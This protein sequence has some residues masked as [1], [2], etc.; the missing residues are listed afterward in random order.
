MNNKTAKEIYKGYKIKTAILAALYIAGL[1]LCFWI[2]TVNSL[3]G[4]GCTVVLA[5]S[6]RA[7][8]EKIRE[9]DLESVIYEELD[10]QKF[11]ELVDL[12]A[13]KRHNRF[14]V[15]AAMNTGDYD[16]VL[17]LVEESEK[18]TDNPVEQCNNLYRK[19]YIHFEKG[20]FD[21]LPHIV[22]EYEALKRKH[23]K[24]AHVFNSYTVFD[25]FDAFADEDYEY[26]IG[27]C[28]IDLK[29]LN[30]KNQN[31]KLTK[32][33]VSFYRAVSLYMM[34]DMDGAKEAFEGII[35][36]APKVHKAK[37][38]REYLNKMN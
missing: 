15:L 33:N 29:E 19:G 3:L 20:E 24:I 1:A 34:G 8:F 36:Y 7:P 21:K 9:K 6:L 16:K 27:V 5:A 23:P 31:H 17:A 13:F 35:E 26:V 30:P 25:K 38:A 22:H 12:G 32:I 14:Q 10:P 18:K 28:D 11:S 37:L 4:I 2:I